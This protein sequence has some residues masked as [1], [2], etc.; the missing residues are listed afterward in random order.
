MVCVFG[1]GVGGLLLSN[2]APLIGDI[3]MK[4]AVMWRLAMCGSLDWKN[5]NITDAKRWNQRLFNPH[6]VGIFIFWCYFDASPMRCNLQPFVSGSNFS[7]TGGLL[8]G[9]EPDAGRLLSASFLRLPLPVRPSSRLRC[10]PITMNLWDL[11][12]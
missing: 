8:P 12:V 2:K 4:S 5:G 3:L 1:G 11:Y 9:R 7:S 10:L 6:H